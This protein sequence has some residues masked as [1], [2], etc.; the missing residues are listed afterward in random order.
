[1][2]KIFEFSLLDEEGQPFTFQDLLGNYSVIYFYPKA[3]TSGCTLEAQQ[4]NELFEQFDGHIIGVSPGSVKA[5]SS[6]RKK[7][8]LKFKLLSDSKKEL[9]QALGIVKDGKLI[10]STFILDPWGRIRKEWINVKVDGHARQVLEVYRK[11]K[12]EDFSINPSILQRRA[13][14]GLR[15]DP[16]EDEKLLRL[17]EAAHLAPSC[18][19]KQ[20][21]RFVV[22]RSKENLKKLHE[23]LSSGNYWM[24]YAPALIIVHTRDDFDCQLS[25]DRNYA[26]FDTGLAVGFL[27][28]QATQM[29]LVAHPVAGYDP[30]KVKELFGIDGRIV[31]L[32]AVGKWGRFEQLNEKHL[33][34]ERSPR[35]RR[36]ISEIAEFL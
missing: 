35:N 11:I 18:F 4:F 31:T 19:N 24:K 15:N 12:E 25:D 34:L 6:F 29:G 20:P 7:Y 14:R 36:E 8:G 3:G 22:V 26:L 16:I 28:V 30:I 33:E 13:F 23:A 5:L 17:I 10:R 2:K 1:M 21:W 32:I 27:L 9:A